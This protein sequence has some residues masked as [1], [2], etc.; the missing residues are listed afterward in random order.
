[1]D[2]GSI[3]I[4]S[5][6]AWRKIV[7]PIIEL[8][9]G[10]ELLIIACQSR[11]QVADT[12]MDV[13]CIAEITAGRVYRHQHHQV[14]SGILECMRSCISRIGSH[15]SKITGT[16]PK[17]PEILNG[18]ADLV[19]KYNIERNTTRSI[20]WYAIYCRLNIG[21]DAS[22]IKF[23]LHHRQV[24]VSLVGIV[25]RISSTCCSW[26]RSSSSAVCTNGLV[27]R[28]ILVEPAGTTIYV[29][30]IWT[31]VLSKETCI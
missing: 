17:I 7:E 11:Y 18:I 30:G 16:I 8:L 31:P 23:N 5:R 19:C 29:I 15:R 27:D 28:P 4:R 20:F 1:P 25:I 22:K 3:R 24:T 6:R 2:K 9:T 21:P 13:R 26:K 14:G 10:I 12:N